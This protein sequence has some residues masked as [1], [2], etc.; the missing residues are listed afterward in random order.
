MF[1][2]VHHINLLVTDL[3]AAARRY[4]DTLGTGDMILAD[5]PERG[6][7][8]ARFAVGETWI[9]LVQ[10]TDPDS[11]PGRHLREH[12]EGLFLLSLQVDSIDDTAQKIR[13]HGG[14]FTSAQP[15]RGLEDWRVM[16]LDTEQ[17]F[18]AQLQVVEDP[19]SP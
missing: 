3:D 15:R 19:S 11:V 7:R 17:F 1:K 18:G 13:E 9:V 8:T 12:G 10:P 14:A 4:R 16:D 5:L 2:R 6:V